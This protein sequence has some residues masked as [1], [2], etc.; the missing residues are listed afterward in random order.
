MFQPAGAPLHLAWPA[1]AKVVLPL[2]A[3]LLPG[4]SEP[5]VHEVVPQHVPD[6]CADSLLSEPVER[7]GWPR[8]RRACAA[9]LLQPRESL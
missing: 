3:L 9:R 5:P 4:R 8:V 6:V 1:R 7:P 2:E